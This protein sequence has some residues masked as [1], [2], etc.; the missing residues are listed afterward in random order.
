MTVAPESW[1]CKCGSPMV[2]VTIGKVPRDMKCAN[3]DCAAFGIV[4]TEPAFA[5]PAKDPSKDPRDILRT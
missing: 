2:F 5:V 3:P 1:R 4:I